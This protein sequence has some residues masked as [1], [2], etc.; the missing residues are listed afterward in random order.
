MY[1]KYLDIQKWYAFFQRID[2]IFFYSKYNYYLFI[3]FYGHSFSQITKL[4]SSGIF[5]RMYTSIHI[6]CIQFFKEYTKFCKFNVQKN[7]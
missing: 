4:V 7:S 5:H 2:T 3:Y 1:I 6:Q